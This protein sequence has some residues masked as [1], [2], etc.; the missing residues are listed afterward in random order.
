MN[1]IT[2]KQLTSLKQVIKRHAQCFH[3]EVNSIL[4]LISKKR[5]PTQLTTNEEKVNHHH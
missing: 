1:K 4:H 5:T 2:L 3:Y